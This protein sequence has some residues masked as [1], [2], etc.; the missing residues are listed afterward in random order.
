MKRRTTWVTLAALLLIL[1]TGL[2]TSI[3]FARSSSATTQPDPALRTVVVVAPGAARPTLR[4]DD[5]AV[6][7]ETG[8]VSA[9]I[10]RATVLTDTDCAADSD[11]ISHCLNDLQI[12]RKQIAI[13]HHHRMMEEPCFSPTEE[14]NVIDATTYEALAGGPS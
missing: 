2:M 1:A 9:G 7:L 11:G 6:D 8:T 12:G 13:R 5:I 14:L 3:N 10:H 4:G